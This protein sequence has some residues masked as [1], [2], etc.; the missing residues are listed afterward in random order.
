MN[1][2]K[3]RYVVAGMVVCFVLSLTT[4]ASIRATESMELQNEGWITTFG[5]IGMDYANAACQT[6]DG[7]YIVVGTNA[8]FAGMGDAWV[9]KT[10]AQGNMGWERIFGGPG[11]EEG[12]SIQQTADGGYI[13]GVTTSSFGERGYDIWLIAT[14]GE[15]N[16]K[17]SRVYGG[18]SHDR[19]ARVQQTTDGGY[20]IAGTTASFGAGATDFWLIKT[21]AH[22]ERIW[23][24]TFGE[25]TVDFCEYVQ[26]TTDGGYILTGYTFSEGY[27][28]PRVWLVKTDAEGKLMWDTVFGGAWRSGIGHCVKQTTDGGYIIAGGTDVYGGGQN[29]DAWLIKTDAYGNMVWHS[30]FGGEGE[31]FGWCVTQTTDGGYIISG[32]TG[33]GTGF[34]TRLMGIS[35][36]PW[37]IK[38]DAGGT[39]EWEHTIGL[40]TGIARCVAQ[41]QDGGY[42]IA[43]HTGT[44]AYPRNVLLAKTDSHGD[45]RWA[46]GPFETHGLFLSAFGRTIGCIM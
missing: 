40:G 2:I 26:Q 6:L 38:T 21:D 46:R 7:G 32:Y 27:T 17:W 11:D 3:R 34:N 13:I 9:I 16:M 1:L 22:G 8:P 10:D 19:V 18:A 37:I 31:E 33:I 42:I 28:H 24:T 25:S 44:L 35:T 5:D 43:G 20:I 15:G 30:S 39:T 41:T 14:D 36:R 23:D 29:L 45:S 12:M 4:D